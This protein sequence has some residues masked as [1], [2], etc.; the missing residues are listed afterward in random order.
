MT[1]DDIEIVIVAAQRHGEDSE[2]DHEVGDL[3]EALRLAWNFMSHAMRNDFMTHATIKDLLAENPGHD[4]AQAEEEEYRAWRPE[5]NKDSGMYYLVR[6][7]PDNRPHGSEVKRNKDGTPEW[8][9]TKFKAQRRAN[10][11]NMED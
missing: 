1:P 9:Q 7:L 10:D 11:L 6:S 4:V 3:Q 8:F 5:R 2:P